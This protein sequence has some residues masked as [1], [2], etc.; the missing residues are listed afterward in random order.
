MI[1]QSQFD[2]V[3]N[4]LRLIGK[5]FKVIFIFKDILI[6]KDSDKFKEWISNVN[7]LKIK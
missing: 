1:N 5:I 6:K 3:V 2:K 4:K 7:D